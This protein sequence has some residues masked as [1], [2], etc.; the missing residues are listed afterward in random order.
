MAGAEK[1]NYV[2]KQKGPHFPIEKEPKIGT[3]GKPLIIES[4]FPGW[5]STEVNPHIPFKTDQVAQ[6]IIDSVKAGAAVIH[7]HP[8]DPEDGRFHRLDPKL[9][10]ATLDPVLAECPD[11]ITWNHSWT[12][13][14]DGPVDYIT[15]TSEL[16]SLGGGNRY[17]QCSV[18]LARDNKGVSGRVLTG[19]QEGGE[20][21]KKGVRFLEENG[22]KPIFQIFDTKGIEFFSQEI[23]GKGYAHWKPFMCC[24]H[25]GKHHACYN[26]K[27]PWSHLQL[28]TS[29]NALKAEIPD[30]VIGLRAGGRNWLPI[31]VAAITYGIEMVGIGMED[32][33]W[34]YP[35]KDEVMS[36]N[37]EVIR[38][39]VTITKELGREVATP[40]QTRQIL[41]LKRT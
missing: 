13:R 31:T 11:V 7:V 6:E 41:K 30:S 3:L 28:L 33:F 10:K 38:K 14:A 5:I 2:K 1:E 20:G 22:V 34:M 9:L 21:I 37:A 27:D 39:I 8:R 26:A 35:H 24:I 15:H 36:K 17:V 12:G 4:A 23:I 19:Y 40:E 25:M 32:C 16:L 18:V 29:L